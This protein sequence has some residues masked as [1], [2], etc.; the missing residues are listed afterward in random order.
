MDIISVIN[1]FAIGGATNMENKRPF[2]YNPAFLSDEELLN[3]F[4]IRGKEFEI[5]IR[6]IKENTGEV[7]QHILLI[8]IRGS[9]KTTLLRRVAAEI[10]RDKE[11]SSKWHPVM[12]SEENYEI[13]SLD[14]F[15]MQSLYYLNDE[16]AG[17][18]ELKSRGSRDPYSEAIGLS[19]LLDFADAQ[20]KR[21]LLIC[22]NL[23]FMLSEIPEDDAWRLRKVLQTDHRIMLLG[24]AT[25]GFNEIEDYK[26]PFYEFFKI[27]TL[28]RISDDDCKILWGSVTGSDD[29]TDNQARA[30]NILT[31]GQPRLLSVIAW[32]G[33]DLLF[34]QLIRELEVLIDDHTEYFKGHIEALPLKERKVFVTLARLWEPSPSSEVSREARMEQTETS[35]LIN[36][37]VKRGVVKE[38]KSG[39][40][41]RAKQYQL[42]ERLYNIYYL[43]RI[44]GKY[45][46]WVEP[47]IE[48]FA[49]VY[50]KKPLEE[51]KKIDT[52]KFDATDMKNYQML[53]SIYASSDA[54]SVHYAD[55][56]TAAIQKMN[57]EV[58]ELYEKGKWTQESI[59]K[60]LVTLEKSIAEL[61]KEHLDTASA[62]HNVGI[63]YNSIT[64]YKKALEFYG[65]ALEIREKVLGEE[66]PDTA[67]TYNNIAVAYAN[68]GEYDKALELYNKTLEIR[69]KVLGEEHPDT[70]WTYRGIAWIYANQGEDDKAL[71]LYNKALKIREKILGEEHPDT[72]RVYNNI[73]DVYVNKG[74]YKK[75]LEYLTKALVCPAYVS[76]NLQRI[77]D[78]CIDIAAASHEMAEKLP[79]MIENSPSCDALSPLAAG[80]KN[81]LGIE[82]NAPLEVREIADDVK[83]WI[84][85]RKKKK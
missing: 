57:E 53:M 71:E 33:K 17:Y 21:I 58:F 84:E 70:A 72:A 45:L 40:K 69:E 73:A 13:L 46:R 59:E 3:S 35:S 68:Q 60:A 6:D 16:R 80:I 26:Q 66:H 42:T 2:K 47:I 75:A 24:S 43:M 8:G 74:E 44:G 11:L 32:F 50:D 83:K 76:R 55:E 64:D 79:K 5:L 38:V 65:R 25:I 27:V 9:G 54:Q 31:G 29:I 51:L 48:F 36:R 67:R 63:F 12:F 34:M 23:Q 22:E 20:N 7:N 39:E 19:R 85:E 62:Y 49:Q 10:K 28:E 61:G 52:T 37:L 18:D 14:D 4:C 81:Y 41:K 56:K 30:L 1:P 15:W 77:N 78:L 82:F